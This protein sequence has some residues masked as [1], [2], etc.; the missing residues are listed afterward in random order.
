[1]IPLRYHN[2]ADGFRFV[3]DHDGLVQLAFGGVGSQTLYAHQ[4]AVSAMARNGANLILDEVVLNEQLRA[5][6]QQLLAGLDVY[7]VGVYCELP[8]LERRERERG[9]RVVGQARG[10]F[11]TVHQGMLYDLEIDTTDTAPEVAA[12]TIAR[13]R[14]SW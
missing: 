3:R 1:M 12:A 13:Q 2:S 14:L 4:E 8:E 9:D 6:W 7:Y 5:N 11:H 10:Q